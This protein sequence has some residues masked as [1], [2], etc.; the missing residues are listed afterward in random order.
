VSKADFYRGFKKSPA[1]H[2]LKSYSCSMPKA[3][4]Q[5]NELE[6]I[7]VRLKTVCMLKYA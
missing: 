2:I 5:N 6:R 3:T 1:K 7:L 4:H